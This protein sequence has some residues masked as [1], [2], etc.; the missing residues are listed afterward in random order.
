MQ[1]T[2]NGYRF[3]YAIVCE[4]DRKKK[5]YISPF[6]MFTKIQFFIEL[7]AFWERERE[8]MKGENWGVKLTEILILW[9]W[10]VNYVCRWATE[11]GRKRFNY[12]RRNYRCIDI[13]GLP[14]SW[15]DLKKNGRRGEIVTDVPLGFHWLIA[16]QQ[17]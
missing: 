3:N 2:F 12:L 10:A 14:I 11:H 8:K 16:D 7:G 15:R 13:R 4:E 6:F 5:F 1:P 9:Y 17:R